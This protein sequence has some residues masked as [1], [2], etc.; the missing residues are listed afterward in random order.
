MKR[1]TEN[2]ATADKAMTHRAAIN[3]ALQLIF[4]GIAKLKDRFPSKA[5]TVDTRLV[6]DIGEVIAALEH[7]ISLYEVQT[8]AHDGVTSGGRKVQV[9][10]TFKKHLTMTAVPDLYL[11]MQLKQ[12]GSHVEI[13]NGPGSL[14][15]QRFAHRT[16]W[17]DRQLSFSTD[18][19]LE[20]SKKV[21]D[22]QRIGY[23]AL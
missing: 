4:S 14:I 7:A 11:G 17:G 8:P 21:P 1:A 5:F 13:Y 12:D 20:L 18:A 3:E 2:Q 10:D 15:A 19:L 22:G 6:G 16:G 9:K 23:S